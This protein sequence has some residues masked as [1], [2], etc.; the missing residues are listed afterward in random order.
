MKVYKLQ[1]KAKCVFCGEGAELYVDGLNVTICRKCGVVLY[2]NLGEHFV[3]RA[4]PNMMLK[5]ERQYRPLSSILIDEEKP[6]ESNT[7]KTTEVFEKKDR[8]TKE[9]FKRFK[10][11]LKNFFKGVKKTN[12]RQTK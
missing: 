7:E 6:Q 4:V 11:R 3:P 1:G 8:K 12:E 10:N 9:I 2:K 5:N